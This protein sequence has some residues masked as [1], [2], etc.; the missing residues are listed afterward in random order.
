[1]SDFMSHCA[2]VQPGTRDALLCLERNK[3]AVSQACQ[4]ALAGLGGSADANPESAPPVAGPGAPESF[5][6]RRPDPRQALGLLR[7]CAPDAFSLCGN[8]PPGD[9]RL[10]ECL[11]QKA[12]RLG[13]QCRAALAKAGG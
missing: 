4:A 3:T 10:I 8:I 9:G 1:M 2:G 11:A 6:M 12:S 5:P 7:A 13:P